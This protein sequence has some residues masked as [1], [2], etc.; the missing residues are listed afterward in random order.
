M[1]TFYDMIDIDAS[2]LRKKICI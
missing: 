1:Y 2:S